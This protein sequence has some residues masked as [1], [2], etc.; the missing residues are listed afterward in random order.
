[1]TLV[2]AGFRAG[3]EEFPDDYELKEWAY[4]GG[5]GE[6]WLATTP[7][8]DGE[9]RH[10]WALKIL[11]A[12]HL[13]A[14]HHESAADAL[15][16]WHL[17]TL[18]AMRE[19]NQLDIPGVIGAS[20][21][22][23]GAPPHRP[24]EAGDSRTLYVASKWIDGVNL[25][26][27]LKQSDRTFVD[28][29]GVAEQLG[30]IIDAITCRPLG[31]LHRDISPANVMVERDSGEVK[32]IDFTFAVPVR[33]GPGTIVVN[34]GYTAP[35][36]R[37]GVGSAAADR[38]SFGAVIYFL[39]LGQPPPEH[40]AGSGGRAALRRA[41]FPG[42]VADHVGTLLATDPQDRPVSLLR[43]A[44]EL[45]AL[46]SA[47]DTTTGEPVWGDVDI[48]IDGTNTAWSWPP[49]LRTSRAHGSLRARCG[50]S[51]RTNATTRHTLRP[52][53]ARHAT[54]RATRSSSRS[55]GRSRCWVGRAD[56]WTREGSASLAGGIAAVRTANGPPSRTPSIPWRNA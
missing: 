22:F 45:R 6:V 25:P 16:R 55:A 20:N 2:E 40:D 21:V 33:S 34:P 7:R 10:R 5:E 39:L 35:E 23:T 37:G 43:W 38:Y 26:N 18:G 24:G 52:A 49:A 36:A 14:N 8:L 41:N 28:V 13:V 29:C 51:C 27:W 3:T 31:I 32:L 15:Q 4:R 53:S 42:A 12:E 19:V 9:T 50:R 1:M 30:R 54:A 11:S 48:T 47:F 44:E 56:G 46:A 17:R